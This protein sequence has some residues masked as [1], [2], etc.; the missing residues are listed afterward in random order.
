M[1]ITSCYLTGT[2]KKV[3]H[4]TFAC[5]KMIQNQSGGTVPQHLS[6][7]RGGLA[8][9]RSPRMRE[10]GCCIPGKDRHKTLTQVVT[11]PPAKRLATGT[12]GPRR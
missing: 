7:S 2:V 12:T 6:K 3:C 1:F 8:V 5:L 4:H 10:I 11:V 9:E